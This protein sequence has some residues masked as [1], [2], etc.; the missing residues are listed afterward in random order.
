M[1]GGRV[2]LP[3]QMNFIPDSHVKTLDYRGTILVT[4][5]SASGA[6]SSANAGGDTYMGVRFDCGSCSTP[7]HTGA[8]MGVRVHA[9][10]YR[11]YAVWRWACG[12]A[13]YVALPSAVEGCSC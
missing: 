11:E 5:N 6:R 9:S 10:A 8:S 7:L 4:L 3:P 13:S 2:S 12:C 1:S